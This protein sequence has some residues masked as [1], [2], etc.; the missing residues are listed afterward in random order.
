MAGKKGYLAGE[1]DHL[2]GKEGYLAG[3]NDYL[4]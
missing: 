3:E 1:K 4:P 2:T